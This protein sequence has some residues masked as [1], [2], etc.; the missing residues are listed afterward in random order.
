MEGFVIWIWELIWYWDLDDLSVKNF[1]M[2]KRFYD[3]L[4]VISFNVIEAEI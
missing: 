2:S 1:Q 4:T 3:N